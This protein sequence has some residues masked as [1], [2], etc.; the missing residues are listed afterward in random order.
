MFL[1]DQKITFDTRHILMKN[2]EVINIY[3]DDNHLHHAILRT[4]HIEI[5]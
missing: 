5:T 1:F 2:A 4:N 3:I